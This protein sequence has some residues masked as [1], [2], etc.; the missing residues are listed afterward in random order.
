MLYLDVLICPVCGNPF[1]QSGTMLKCVQ[2][3][4]FDIAREGYVNLSRKTL[5]GDS[6]EMLMARRDFFEHDYYRPISDAINAL[7]RSHLD[8]T[9]PLT[10][11]TILDAGCGEGYYIDRLRHS[12]TDYSEGTG[13]IDKPASLSSKDMGVIDNPVSLASRDVRCVGLDIS[14][15]AIKLAARRYRQ[16]CFVVANLKERLV[17]ADQALDAITNIFAP[18]NADEFA[19]ILVPGGLLLIVI[20]APE[21]LHQLRS[22]LHL[23]DIEENKQQHVIAQFSA[24]F[25]LLTATTTRY[26][27]QLDTT[28][29]RQIVMMTPNYWHLTD[30]TKAAMNDLEQ[31]QTD[32]ACTYLLFRRR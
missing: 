7:M 16:V 30:E 22:T 18:R 24:Q 17:I 13:A 31:L 27:V 14:K 2:G 19:R 15:E 5:P 25:E 6:R 11:M 3:H 32:V 20:P 23:L 29:I 10:P 26:T 8:L 21:H 28:A 1:T 4:S 9:M 12:L